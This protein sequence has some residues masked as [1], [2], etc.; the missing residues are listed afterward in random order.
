M[1]RNRV[2][3][4]LLQMHGYIQIGITRIAFDDLD[5]EDEHH[6]ATEVTE[7]NVGDLFGFGQVDG[8]RT[9]VVAEGAVG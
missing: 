6:R 8:V 2:A 3:E 5:V 4:R 7:V 9:V 1:H